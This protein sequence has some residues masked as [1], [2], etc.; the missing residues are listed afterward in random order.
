MKSPRWRRRRREEELEAEIQSHLDLAIHDRMERGETPER[1]RA[2]A[3]R[4]F[5]NVGLVK[6]VT[7]EIWGWA[8]L[9][10]LL[11]DL[12]FGLRM[13]RKNPGIS[14]IAIL[15]LALVIGA[16]TALFSVVESVLLNTLPVKEPEALVLFE[17]QAGLAFRT[18]GMSG[19]VSVPEAPGTQASSVF[20]HEVFAQMR[21]AQ[22][23]TL[24]SPLSD[25][26]AFAPLPRLNAVAGQQAEI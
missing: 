22:A 23:A 18:S 10:R 24:E 13:L 25:F 1:A 20:R 5:G 9:E 12:R 14:L 8:S 17:W 21:Q 19:Y 7:R 2:N 11:Q 16:N 3:L 6:E 15:T 26:F 4:E